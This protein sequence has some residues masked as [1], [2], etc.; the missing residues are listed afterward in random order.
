MNLNSKQ[1]SGLAAEDSRLA[2]ED[3]GYITEGQ[4]ESPYVSLAMRLS[5]LGTPFCGFARQPGKLTVQ[6]EIEK[7][8][9]I[10]FRR[11]IETVCAGRTDSGVHAR[12]QVVSFELT[13][14]ELEGRNLGAL[15]RS[16]NALTHD[17]IA[18]RELV[19][20]P[21][22]FS[23]RFDAQYR[24]YRYRLYRGSCSPLL[25]A[26]FTWDMG[27][28]GTLDI[29]AMKLAA[30]YLVGEH[31]FKS[32][33]VSASAQGRNTIREVLDLQIYEED[34]LGEPGVVVKIVGKAF[35]HSMVRIIVGT[36]AE[37]AC[38]RKAPEW[39]AEVLE[40]KDRSRAGQT[41]PAHGLI[42]WH[43]DYADLI[44]WGDGDTA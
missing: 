44:A 11:D 23:A 21:S 6:G 38:G 37:I 29:D 5:Y 26:N 28:S 31:D 35:L 32:F 40:A 19:I 18:S 34:L 24:E 22:G 33:C 4:D 15:S 41:A 12:E 16:I 8:L 1:L 10:I 9:S 17:G 27:Y 20:A 30:K 43:V 13:R 2:V 39:L 3:S 7:A 14:E 25:S 36:I 42:F